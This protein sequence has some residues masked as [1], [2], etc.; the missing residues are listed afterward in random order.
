MLRFKLNIKLKI[1][2]LHVTV[3]ARSTK[4]R[5]NPKMED[6]KRRHPL[7]LRDSSSTDLRAGEDGE[8]SCNEVPL[9]CQRIKA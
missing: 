6:A 4:K 1:K 3:T 8:K 9:H 2:E 5:R 7:Q